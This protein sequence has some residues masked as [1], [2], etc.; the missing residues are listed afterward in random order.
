M[1]VMYL[2]IT[3]VEKLNLSTLLAMATASS[4]SSRQ[5][6]IPRQHR[7]DARIASAIA[8]GDPT[9]R[10]P[11]VGSPRDRSI[12]R[13]ARRSD[14]AISPASH[15]ATEPTMGSIAT[16]SSASP[17]ASSSAVCSEANREASA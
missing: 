2:N 12:A 17:M 4:K 14:S 9:I 10:L 5:P 13:W 7:V 16:D 6:S 11:I 8:S 1:I 15:L 3:T